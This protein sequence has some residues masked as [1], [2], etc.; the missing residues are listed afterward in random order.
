MI[1]TVTRNT[2]IITHPYNHFVR[3]IVKSDKEKA[4]FGAA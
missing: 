4:A 1:A 3:N 2:V